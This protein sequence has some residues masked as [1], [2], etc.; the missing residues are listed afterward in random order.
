MSIPQYQSHTLVRAFKIRR[1]VRELAGD[2]VISPEDPGLSPIIVSESWLRT[3]NVR[4]GGYYV[5][6]TDGMVTY[7]PALDF[8]SSYTRLFNIGMEG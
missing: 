4:E 8:E 3:H 6:H 2:F 1:I 7:M 5:L